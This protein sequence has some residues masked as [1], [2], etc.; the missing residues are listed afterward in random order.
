MIWTPSKKI[1]T[2]RHRQRGNIVLTILPGQDP[3][4]NEVVLLIDADEA[5]AG[6]KSIAPTVGPTFNAV[7]LSGGV[8]E[9]S[10]LQQ[11]FGSNSLRSNDTTGPTEA[12]WQAA[13]VSP[14]FGFGT[15]DFTIEFHAYFPAARSLLA[16][17]G[18]WDF[19]TDRSWQMQ[20]DTTAL[21][22]FRTAFGWSTTGAN[23]LGGFQDLWSVGSHPTGGALNTWY[24]LATT[25]DG[26]NVR[27]FV[28]GFQ[29]GSTRN[30]STNSVHTSTTL[31]LQLQG[32][33]NDGFGVEN[34]ITNVRIT[35]GSARYTTNF[36]PPDAQYP[37]F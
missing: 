21:G 15:G 3:L 7:E 23:S 14:N 34:F 1:L 8:A 25:R 9:V 27:N 17:M 18:I 28:D 29:V 11:K 33:R 32:A 4:F 26:A 30:I 2:S 35:K 22:D 24:H 37:D 36:T 6:S 5:G 10:A 19:G 20:I 16:I 12:Y 31:P 13:S